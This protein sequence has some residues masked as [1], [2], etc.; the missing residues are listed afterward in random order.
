MGTGNEESVG[1]LFRLPLMSSCWL[2]GS[3]LVL[4]LELPVAGAMPTA[5]LKL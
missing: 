2:I 5:C 4:L 3:S 1:K